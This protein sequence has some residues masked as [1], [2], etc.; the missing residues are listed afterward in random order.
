MND[1][2]QNIEKVFLYR[3]TKKFIILCGLFFIP[4]SI[5]ILQQGLT[6]CDSSVSLKECSLGKVMLFILSFSSLGLFLTGLYTRIR[7]E[8]NSKNNRVAFTNDSI[9]GPHVGILKQKEVEIKYKDIKEVKVYIG[10]GGRYQN[11]LILKILSGNND[12]LIQE[13]Y[14]EENEFEQICNLLDQKINAIEIFD[15]NSASQLLVEN[16]SHQRERKVLIAHMI[17]FFISGIVYFAFNE[18]ADTQLESDYFDSF[19]ILFNIAFFAYIVKHLINFKREL[20]VQNNLSAQIGNC[21]LLCF[22]VFLGIFGW[23]GF[24]S[25]LNQLHDNSLAQESTTQLIDERQ[26]PNDDKCYSIKSIKGGSDSFAYAS[27]CDSKYPDLYD[28]KK[29]IVRYK[30]GHFHQKWMVDFKL[31]E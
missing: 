7:S 12:I 30:E 22:G 8:S 9:L 17:P 21:F 13:L 26:S 23:T 16:E 25:Y 19:S 1:L 11:K 18:Y 14:L 6:P 10:G 31:V 28:G 27:I 24:F 5:F 29:I 20:K 4:A 3:P 2:T 15:Y